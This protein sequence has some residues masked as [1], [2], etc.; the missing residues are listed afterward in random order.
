MAVS[1]PVVVGVD[2]SAAAL[3]A[4]RWAAV[5]AAR[6]GT[7]LVVFHAEL[8]D[9]PDLLPHGKPPGDAELL[10]EP[11]HR[12]LRQAAE[13]ARLTAPAVPVRMCVRLGTAADLL[14]ALSD[15]AGLLALGAHGL[16]GA[17]GAAIG[18]VALRA[19][20]SARCPVV[21]IRGSAAA[22][23]PV[24]VGLD[25]SDGGER[26]LAFAFEAA[27]SRGA[28]LEAVHAWHDGRPGRESGLREQVAAWSRKHPLVP[29]RVHVVRV[30]S[31]ARAL[32][33]IS[34]GAQLIVAGARA[35]GP[36]AGG[37]LGSTGYWLLAHA[38]CP[39]AV[40]R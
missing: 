18:S 17:R 40:A 3:A 9:D 38:A 21:V 16:G 31:A 26:A 11:A 23:G 28:G 15:E 30:R 5:E 6:R 39:V 32:A 20:A 35:R 10:L 4:V 36:V 2:G 13:T 22:D 1:R 14:A 33:G 7:G 19:A 37:L 34:A 29:V 24:V 12:L 25:D 8:C 27:V